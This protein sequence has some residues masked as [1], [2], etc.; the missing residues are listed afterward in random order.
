MLS[1]FLNNR[2]LLRYVLL[3]ASLAISPL[4]SLAAYASDPVLDWIAIANDTLISTNSN[5][6]VTARDLALISSSVFDSVN[7]IK[8]DYEPYHVRPNAPHNASAKAAAIQ[9]AYAMLIKLFPA[10]TTSLTTQRDASIAA[11]SPKENPWSIQQGMAWGQ[12]VADAIWALRLNDGFSP[13]PPPFVGVLGILTSPSAIGVWR[14]TPLLNAPGAGPQFATMTPWVLKRPS[15]FRLPPPNALTSPEYAVDY[16]EVKTMGSYNNSGRS[17]DQSELALFWA[18]NTPLYWDR[19]ASQI[20]TERWFSVS[21]NAHLFALLNITMADAAIACWDSKY[22]YVY[23]RPVTAIRSGDL[24]GN[25]ATDPDPLWTPWL[26]FFPTGTPA[27]PEYPS[28]HSTVSGSAAAILTRFFGDETAFTVTSDVRP[29][30]RSFS[31]FTSAVNE[32]ANARV[33]G[34]IHNRTSCVRGNALG[35]TVAAYVLTHALREDRDK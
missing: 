12:T 24:D 11:L 35:Q 28:G 31:S 6:L 22:R 29:G 9:S 33:F 15:Q 4:V 32:I 18:G 30:T 27:H 23:W 5:P 16:N 34:G 19:I 1:N 17:S 14:P 2:S 26:D 25:P 8:R 3:L 10:L 20:A 7:G 13:P 21:E